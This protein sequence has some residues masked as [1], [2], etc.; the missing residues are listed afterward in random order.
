[1]QP[2]PSNGMPGAM[3]FQGRL[4]AAYRDALASW[5]F[6]NTYA[7]ENLQEYWAEGVQNWYNTNLE[8]IPANG[9]HTRSTSAP[10]SRATIRCSTT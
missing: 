10:S 6:A 4:R 7:L 5:R 3:T 2:E 9:I 8:A 1:M